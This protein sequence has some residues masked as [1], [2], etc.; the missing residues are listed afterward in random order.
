MVKQGIQIIKT[1][2]RIILF[3][4]IPN[5][6]IILYLPLPLNVPAEPDD[7]SVDVELVGVHLEAFVVFIIADD[8]NF[9]LGIEHLDTFDH[10]FVNRRNRGAIKGHHPNKRK[11]NI[12]YLNL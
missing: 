4:K 5:E 2:M 11:G 9:S 6:F 7:F 8:R 3:I 1:A 10:D 12:I